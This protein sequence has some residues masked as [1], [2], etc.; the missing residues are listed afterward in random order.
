MTEQLQL[1]RQFI[2]EN[3]TSN[4][5]IDESKQVVKEIDITI[6]P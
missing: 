4:N 3:L 2:V 5:T 1:N 6:T